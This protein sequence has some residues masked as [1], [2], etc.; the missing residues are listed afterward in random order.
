MLIWI[1]SSELRFQDSLQQTKMTQNQRHSD[2]ESNSKLHEKNALKMTTMTTKSSNN[3]NNNNHKSI[4]TTHVVDYNSKEKKSKSSSDLLFSNNSNVNDQKETETLNSNTH[5]SSSFHI[6]NNKSEPSESRKDTNKAEGPLIQV[7]NSSCNEKHH[8]TDDEESDDE[9]FFPPCLSP[10]LLTELNNITSSN[11]QPPLSSSN[12]KEEEEEGSSLM[13]QMMKEALLQK[14]QDEEKKIQNQR[15]QAKQTKS[16]S[17]FKAGFLSSSTKKSKKNVSKSKKCKSLSSSSSS[18]TMK[19]EKD[20]QDS[21]T[22]SNIVYELDS[23]GNMIPSSITP[24]PLLQSHSKNKKK[25]KE[26]NDDDIPFLKANKQTKSPPPI[27]LPSPKIP[28]S[29]EWMTSDLMNQI[30]SNPILSKGIQNP[31]FTKILEKM[32]HCPKETF[33]EISSSDSN[34]SSEIKEFIMEYMN[35]LGDHFTQLGEDEEKKQRHSDNK[36]GEEGWILKE[37]QTKKKDPIKKEEVKENLGPFV[38][39]ALKYHQKAEE[40]EMEIKKQD[41]SKKRNSSSNKP[42]NPSITE[43]KK[44]QE[45]LQNKSIV[46]I[47]MDPKIQQIMTDCSKIPGKMHYYLSHE[48]YGPQ[49]KQLL[50]AGLLQIQ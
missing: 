44:V 21:T 12:E 33:Q 7:L 17:G 47:L 30:S 49:L 2:F 50:N 41:N 36:K 10:P 19:K 43:D 34:D 3:N 14:K 6:F 11:S 13:E 27:S 24:P 5:S 42:N 23:D 28:K 16:F 22:D 40:E 9:E 38:E 31:K 8:E 32:Q 1:E 46:N 35:V 29:S 39:K 15:K 20:S 4:G 25:Q 18:V 45:I 26:S 37:A 48:M